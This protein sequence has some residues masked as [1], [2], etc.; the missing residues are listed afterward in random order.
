MFLQ[1]QEVEIIL[2]KNIIS[3]FVLE[4]AKDNIWNIKGN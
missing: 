1:F 3:K 2:T 4:K